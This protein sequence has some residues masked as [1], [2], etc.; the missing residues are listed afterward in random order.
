[1][2]VLELAAVALSTVS[3]V[4]PIIL[5]DRRIIGFQASLIF[6]PSSLF[7]FLGHFSISTASFITV[8]LPYIS[9]VLRIFNS[10]N[11]MLAPSRLFGFF[12][13]SPTFPFFFSLHPF[14]VGFRVFRLPLS[15]TGLLTTGAE[16]FVSYWSLHYF[17]ILSS[18]LRN[19]ISIFA[20]VFKTVLISYTLATLDIRSII[21]YIYIYI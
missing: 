20:L 12:R 7:N 10:L 6:R 9:S 19:K 16:D 18:R 3:S 21:S 13:L 1:M 11:P 17:Q 15:Y 8:R 4:P 5:P 14:R 2:F